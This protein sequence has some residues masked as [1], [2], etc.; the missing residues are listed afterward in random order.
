LV[1]MV[2]T[3][4]IP[5]KKCGNPSKSIPV[6]STVKWVYHDLAWFINLVWVS[7]VLK[8]HPL[9]P[10]KWLNPSRMRTS[11]PPALVSHRPH[12]IQRKDIAVLNLN[13]A[14]KLKLMFCQDILEPT[15]GQEFEKQSNS[16]KI[17]FCI[18]L[19]KFHCQT[20]DI[21]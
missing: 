4:V 19:L 21:I 20:D 9:T 10:G 13:R 16:F 12:R 18:L 1:L 2:P 8:I 15:N 17:K 6:K 3:A 7:I 14:K 11:D 5:K